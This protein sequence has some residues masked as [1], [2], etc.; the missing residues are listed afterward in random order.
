M[1]LNSLIHIHNELFL[2]KLHPFYSDI[3]K[4]KTTLKS[5]QNKQEMFTPA[6]IRHRLMLNPTKVKQRSQRPID[7]ITAG[8]VTFVLMFVQCFSFWDQKKAVTPRKICN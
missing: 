4:E 7:V 3:E 8:Y 1:H 6:Y 2:L 5:G